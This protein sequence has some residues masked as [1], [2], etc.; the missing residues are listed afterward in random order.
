MTD[1]LTFEESMAKLTEMVTA[2]EEGNLDLDEMIKIY[3][4]AVVL[5]DKCRKVLEESERKVRVLME[6]S[7]GIT[8]ENLD[9]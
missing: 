8:T 1:E 3:E 7:N 2:L 5:R 4:E 9:I 6:S